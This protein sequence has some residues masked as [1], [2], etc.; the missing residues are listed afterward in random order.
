MSRITF[1]LARNMSCLEASVSWTILS[2]GIAT[3]APGGPLFSQ[4]TWFFLQSMKLVYGSIK[5][6]QKMSFFMFELEFFG[7]SNSGWVRNWKLKTR[8]LKPLILVQTWDSLI[9]EFQFSQQL[10]IVALQ[11]SAFKPGIWTLFQFFMCN[12]W[13][14]PKL[15][16]EVNVRFETQINVW[17]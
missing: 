13:E 4:F 2:F 11:G 6:N 15:K 5:V 14:N 7:F 17:V 10:L 8:V 9:F 12:C 1:C 3:G 16:Y